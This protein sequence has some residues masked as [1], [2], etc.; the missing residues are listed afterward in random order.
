MIPEERG[1]R[2]DP[3]AGSPVWCACRRKLM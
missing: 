3:R 1:P 2:G